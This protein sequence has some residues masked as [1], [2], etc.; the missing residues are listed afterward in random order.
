MAIDN[1]SSTSPIGA[2]TLLTFNVCRDIVS[3]ERVCRDVDFPIV[4][5]DI[6]ILIFV[7]VPCISLVEIT[8]LC[9]LSFQY[10]S[11]MHQN[12]AVVAKNTT[13]LHVEKVWK[14]VYLIC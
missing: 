8:R 14:A 7:G 6:N 11:K 5:L 2:M 10:K 4:F 12:L 13:K 9:Y 3:R 1:T